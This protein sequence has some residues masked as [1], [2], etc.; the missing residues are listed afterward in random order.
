MARG[1]CVCESVC[2]CECGVDVTREGAE[3]MLGEGPWLGALPGWVWIISPW[4]L[5]L[6]VQFALVVWG[7]RPLVSWE[8]PGWDSRHSVKHLEWKVYGLGFSFALLC[9]PGQSMSLSGTQFLPQ[10]DARH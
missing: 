7:L 8:G 9:D 5:H 2:A 10:R 6:F 3:W 1:V 4:H